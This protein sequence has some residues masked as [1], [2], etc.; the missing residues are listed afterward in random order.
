MKADR[1]EAILKFMGSDKI[2]VDGDEVRASCPFAEFLH[3]K[4][5]DRHPS[6]GVKVNPEGVSVY[7]CFSCHSG[8]T[9]QTMMFKWEELTG[10]RFPGDMIAW[11]AEEVP[12]FDPDIGDY[13]TPRPPPPDELLPETWLGPFAGRVH[14]YVLDRGITVETAKAWEIGWDAR[15]RRATFPVRNFKGGLVGI[16]SRTV[17]EFD[18]RPKY[19]TVHNVSKGLHFY[20]EWR[21]VSK[22]PIMLV[23]GVFDVIHPWQ[24]GHRDVMGVLGSAL[25][26]RQVESLIRLNRTVYFC[27]DG[28]FAGMFGMVKALKDLGDHVPVFVMSYPEGEREPTGFTESTLEASF[29]KAEVGS[30]WMVEAEKILKAEKHRKAE[31]R[32]LERERKKSDGKV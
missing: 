29:L 25:T 19:T 12:T 23:E 5:T 32:R 17:D 26:K 31:A 24:L 8:D 10:K 9:L 6:F 14:K 20:G 2:R 30:V 13:D 27:F 15:N 16:I 21:A 3:E 18:N 11:V 22:E 1:I 4:S 28:D 7:N